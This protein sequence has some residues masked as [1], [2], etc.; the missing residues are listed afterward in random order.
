MEPVPLP[1]EL[2]ASLTPRHVTEANPS[3]ESRQQNR[4][5]TPESFR[6]ENTRPDFS[7]SNLLC[8]LTPIA[9]NYPLLSVKL[10]SRSCNLF[11][12]ATMGLH[13]PQSTR[14][15]IVIGISLAFFIAEISSKLPTAQSLPE[16]LI[17]AH[18]EFPVGFYTS[19]LALVADAFHYV[20]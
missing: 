19:S 20:I 8:L 2:H 6:A 14:L 17:F 16:T 15:Q 1:R 18:S 7:F 4:L 13:L 12:S 11:N 3:S 5:R 9:L 10:P